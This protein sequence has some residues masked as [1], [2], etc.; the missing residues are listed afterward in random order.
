MDADL[1]NETILGIFSSII[2]GVGAAH[3]NHVVHR[4]L[5]P[6]NI[7]CKESGEELVVA[8]FGIAHFTD[9]LLITAVEPKT[10]IGS[11]IFS[12]QHRSSAQGAMRLIVDQ[13]FTD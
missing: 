8:D 13:T 12:I 6:E 9:D 4:D 7:L 2:D 1:H 5:K 3:L 11:L 10:V